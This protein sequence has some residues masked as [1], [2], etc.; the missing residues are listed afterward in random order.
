MLAA[1]CAGRSEYHEGNGRSGGAAGSGTVSAGGAAGHGVVNSGGT[2]LTS[3]GGSSSG[4]VINTG[5]TGGGIDLPDASFALGGGGGVPTVDAGA[6][7]R[8][9]VIPAASGDIVTAGTGGSPSSCVGGSTSVAGKGGSAGGGMAGAGADAGAGAKGP[10]AVLCP[11][12]SQIPELD[13]Y[14]CD[15]T[16]RRDGW[17]RLANVGTPTA[18]NGTCCYDLIVRQTECL[19]V[20]RAFLVD[21]GLVRSSVREGQGWLFGPMP[22]L[23]ELSPPTRAA[24]TE[25]WLK[26]AAFEHA[27]VATFAR[28]ALQLL[29]VG[30]PAELLH[31]T[32][33]AGNDEIRHAELCFTLAS[34]YAGKLLEP[35]AFPIGDTLPIQ[36]DLSDIVA[37][38][39]VEGCIGETLAAVQAQAQLAI[40]TDEAVLESL[41]STVEDESRHAELAWRVVAWALSVGGPAVRRIAERAFAEFE[42]PKAPV[43]DLGGVDLVAFA[44]HGRLT[45]E[46]AR[47]VALE[48][49]ALVVRPCAAALLERDVMSHL[50][51]RSGAGPI[52]SFASH[53]GSAGLA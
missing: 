47:A 14:P 4:G 24:L 25:A 51:E 35:D 20:G 7:M 40:T 48:T 19:Y 43:I 9:C 16:C 53:K 29:A 11:D 23:D 45:P 22:D 27:S 39:I 28:F 15:I 41:R 34:A 32:M 49:L 38:T 46:H 17:E 50:A 31:A 44:A 18:V 8:I 13:G 36:R 5:A 30:A 3:A 12:P 21:D 33:S 52:L 2:G 6:N 26:D 42:P 10:P 1:A 37:E